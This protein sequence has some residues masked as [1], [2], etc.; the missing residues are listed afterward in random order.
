MQIKSKPKTYLR[1][2]F[3]IKPEII[4]VS[5]S[6]RKLVFKKTPREGQ[7]KAIK[8][9]TD[10]YNT[11]ENHTAVIYLHGKHGCGKSVT[12]LLLAQELNA[13]YCSTY[14]PTQPGDSINMIY[15]TVCPSAES[16]LIIVFEECDKMIEKVHNGLIQP[17][18]SLDI[19]VSDKSSLN[20]LLD[21][22][23][24]GLYP[25]LILIMISNK[26]DTEINALDPSY[27][28]D[29]RVNLKIQMQ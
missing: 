27:L 24:R 17:H 3:I 15:N 21:W 10:F 19:E 2:T 22:I 7:L 16:P 12:C 25:N 5:Y 20:S 8:S 9:I 6:E 14:N 29:G 18:K 1:S 4:L 26:S 11:S 13:S 28:R 23:D